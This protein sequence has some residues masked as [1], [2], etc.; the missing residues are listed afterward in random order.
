MACFAE[1]NLKTGASLEFENEFSII[2]ISS[3]ACG[4]GESW[5]S[6]W[7]LG[8]GLVCV[9]IPDLPAWQPEAALFLT[10]AT[11]ERGCIPVGNHGLVGLK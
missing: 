8:N 1:N 7:P 6:L 5:R 3:L 2:K 9:S 10:L 4:E 11:G